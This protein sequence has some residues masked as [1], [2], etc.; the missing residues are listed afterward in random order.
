MST[1]R[2]DFLKYTGYLGAATAAGSIPE[3]SATAEEPSKKKEV[4]KRLGPH[5]KGVPITIAGYDYNRVKA[6]AEGA[7]TVEGCSHQFEVTS[8]GP[9]NEHAFYGEKSRDV[10]EIGLIPYLLAF[11]NGGFR[12]YVL[13]PIPLLRLFRH[14]SIYVRT[15]RGI[16]TPQDLRGK[17]VATVGYSS[18]GLTHVR[19][20]LK[21][22]YGVKPDEIHWISTTKDSGS[23]L[24]GETASRW[25]KVEPKGLKIDAA[26]EGEDDSSLLLKGEVD[27]I[28]HPAEPKIYQDRNP[29]VE[30]LFKDHRSVEQAYFK[31]TGLFPIM[32][33]VA[34]R[35]KTIQQHPWLPKAVFKAYS[36]AKQIDYSHMRNWGWAMDSLPWYG[37]EFNNTRELMGDNFYP[38]GLKASAPSY[39]KAIEYVYDQGLSK[40]KLSI[41]ELFEPSTVDLVDESSGQL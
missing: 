9:L 2:R 11:A 27:A 22:E 14:K 4:K 17:K 40:R 23:N 8:I 13:L 35:V 37:Q 26:P 36:Q 10:T 1:N 30:R 38:Y 18:S 3:N 5:G 15:D 41:D 31:K 29:L 33:S 19:G 6:L 20:F 32:H 39:E 24:T 28:F 21:D 34:V 7:V 25:E 16:K 12:D